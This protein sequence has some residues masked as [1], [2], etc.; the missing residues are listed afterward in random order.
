MQLS[1]KVQRST[2]SK[3]QSTSAKRLTATRSKRVVKELEHRAATIAAVTTPNEF[4]KH[5]FSL[6]LNWT[7]IVLQLHNHSSDY[8]L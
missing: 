5:Y 4:T 2:A 1:F 3:F 8:E 6:Y 7:R